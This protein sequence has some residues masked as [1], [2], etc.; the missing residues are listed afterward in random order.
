MKRAKLVGPA[1]LAACVG[2]LSGCQSASTANRAAQAAAPVA[3]FPEVDRGV[4]VDPNPLPADRE[5]ADLT[6]EGAVARGRAEATIIDTRDFAVQIAPIQVDRENQ[7]AVKMHLPPHTRPQIPV[8]EEAGL[9]DFPLG[10]TRDGLLV[11]PG[12]IFQFT[13]LDRT[14]WTPPDPAL[15][16]GPNHV[17]VTVNQTLGFYRKSDGVLLFQQI[18]GSQGSPGFF[19]PVG[20]GT[21]TFDPKCFYDHYA[22]RFVILALEVYSST[23]Y[24]TIAVSDDSNPEGTWYKY[25]TDAVINISG[26]TYWWD[27]PGLGFDDDAYYVTGNLFGLNNGGFAGAGFRVFDKADMLTGSPVDFS[28]L[29]DGGGGSV[30]C[31]QHFGNNPAPFFVSTANSGSLRLYAITNPLTSPVLQQTFVS[32]PSFSTTGD[33]PVQGGGSLFIVDGRI[34]NAQ[35]RNGK[36]YTTHHISVGGVAKPRWYEINMNNWPAS[37]SPSLAQSG[38]ADPG[39]GIEGFFPAIY[40]NNA[41][42]VAMVY[43]TSSSTRTVG[44]VVTGRLPSDPAGFMATPVTI[45]QSPNGGSDGRW[46]D[47]Y[48]IALDPNDGTTFWVVGETEESFGWDTRVA[49]FRLEAPPCPADLAP[50]FGILDLADIQAFITAFQGQQ[51]AA[52][53][54]AP[55]GVFDLADIQAFVAAFSAGCQ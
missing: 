14:G 3:V 4:L 20:G 10:G 36:L 24:I 17:V 55:F 47:Y 43:G 15:A 11:D 33:A 5:I 25:R 12:T 40:T 7:R 41:G 2:L 51:A 26:S 21:F 22:G 34:F 31:A 42:G 32:V 50:P 6:A 8:D 46:G 39:A 9:K 16:V 49:S 54:A 38:N 30:Q 19:E 52:D 29:R 37:G 35:W 27:Y 13:A 1:L 45:R 48:D 53:L 18:L 44:M 23:A 28:T